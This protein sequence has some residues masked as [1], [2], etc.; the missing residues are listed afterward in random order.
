MLVRASESA[1]VAPQSVMHHTARASNWLI[2]PLRL[3]YR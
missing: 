2:L 3:E 1:K